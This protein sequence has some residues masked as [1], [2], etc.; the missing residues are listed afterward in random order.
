MKFLVVGEVFLDENI[1][2]M[3]DRLSPEAPVLVLKTKDSYLQD[4]LASL[5]DTYLC[6][7]I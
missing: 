5:L 3:S 2:G 7:S 4:Q 6:I 1:I